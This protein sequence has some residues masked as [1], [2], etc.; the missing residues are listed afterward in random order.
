M[1]SETTAVAEQYR[2]QEWVNLIRNCQS[3]PKG[4]KID[5]W[6][7]ANGTTRDSYYYWLRKLRAACLASN[8]RKRSEIT[9]RSHE[10]VPVPMELLKTEQLAEEADDFIELASH[11]VTLK[12]TSKTSSELLL[13]VLGVLADAE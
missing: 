13:K 2:M 12:V 8:E 4:M 7:S 5:E 9:S 10:I 1:K 3:R 6:C 11:G